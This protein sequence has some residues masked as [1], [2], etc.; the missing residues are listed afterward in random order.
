MAGV[1]LLTLHWLDVIILGILNPHLCAP[2]TARDTGGG[3]ASVARNT[4]IQK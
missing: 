1:S 3:I 2:Q 4:S